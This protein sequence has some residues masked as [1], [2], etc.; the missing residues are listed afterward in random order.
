LEPGEGILLYTDGV[1]E[2]VN[3]QGEFFGDQRLESYLAGCGSSRAQA[4]VEG[5][6]AAVAE[7]AI[8]VPRADDITVLGLRYF[9]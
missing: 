4:L 3:K 6:H 9:G 1:P 5:L 2:A 8:G 7:F